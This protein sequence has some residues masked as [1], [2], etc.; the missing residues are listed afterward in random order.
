MSNWPPEEKQ[1]VPVWVWA[2]VKMVK[3]VELWGLLVA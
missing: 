2:S 1:S 3:M